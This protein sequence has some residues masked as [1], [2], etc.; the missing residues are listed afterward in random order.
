VR[1]FL[2]ICG[3]LGVAACSASSPDAAG[4]GP[5]FFQGAR[6]IRGDAQ[7][8]IERSAFIV[9]G[10]TIT[11]VGDSA[12]LQPPPGA[13]VVDLSGKTVMPAL[14]DGHS[15]LGYTDVRAGSTSSS[16]YTRENL[17][18]HL[19]RYAYY[20]IAATLSLGLDRGE[21]PFQL[22]GET[23]TDAALFLT[24]GR[25]IAMPNAGPRA[26]YWRDAPYGVTT[27]SE[28]R[29]AV[30]ELASRR[31]T[32]VKI[33]VDDRDGTVTP[34]PPSLYRPI[35][36]EAH[37]RGLKVVAHVYYLADAKALLRSGIDGFA[38]GIRD[39]EVDEEILTLF[40]ER[41]AVFVLPNLPDTPPA[42]G[43]LEWLSET[44]PAAQIEASRRSADAAP[45]RPRLFVVQARSLVKLR[46]AGVRIGFGTDAGI[47]APYGWSAHAE[48]ADMVDAGLTPAQ[49]IVA[50]TSTTASILGLDRLG[51]LAPGK[52]ADFIVLDANP[53]EDVRHTRRIS[54]VYLRGAMVDRAA[55]GRAFTGPPSKSL[56][57]REH[58]DRDQPPAVRLPPTDLDEVPRIL[59]SVLRAGHGDGHR[60]RPL[61][62]REIIAAV[63]S[64]DAKSEVLHGRQRRQAGF[65]GGVPPDR[66]LAGRVQ[67]AIA[68]VERDERLQV[69]RNDPACEGLAG[70][71]NRA[72]VL[73]R[74]LRRLL[75]VR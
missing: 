59:N 40:R 13:T 3:A 69:A 15:H 47:G 37:A 70:V 65:D 14:I 48:L 46:D 23:N 54:Q 51:T 68:R 57:G 12:T 72:H 49:A 55:A 25:G 4:P 18:D 6:L 21:L 64:G 36:D 63:G 22:R 19:R 1:A 66:R 7:A 35:I 27:E 41:P 30:R 38:H 53:L 20:G 42:A 10:D 43:D 71:G 34:L 50:A 9:E 58:L 52:Q 8:P 2:A 45:P 61:H 67:H 32:M 29:A 75:R 5:T 16:H 17:L 60:V 56:V 24:A 39:R 74:Q 44:L 62:V 33:W 31:V 26:D 11:R 73:V 28:A